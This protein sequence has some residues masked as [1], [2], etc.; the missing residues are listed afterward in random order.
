[1]GVNAFDQPDV[2]RAKQ[3]ARR[4]LQNRAAPRS[5]DGRPTSSDAALGPSDPAE[6]AALAVRALHEGDA[7]VVLAY[8]PETPAAIRSL[9][10][11]RRHVRDRLR[12]A[13][14]VG[15]GPR[16]LHSTGQLFKGGPERTVGLVVYAPADEDVE[17]PG[18]AHT[19]G[20]LLHAQALGDYEAMRSLGRRVFFAALDSP[21]DLSSLAR[22]VAAA[23]DA[24]TSRTPGA[25]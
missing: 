16:Y 24:A 21:R 5:A 14:I 20:D 23:A 17:V 3:A 6:T 10:G 25:R 12:C 9:A 7:F 4:A 15:F 1:M 8:T 13:T 11:M 2:E 19:L 18:V 22:A